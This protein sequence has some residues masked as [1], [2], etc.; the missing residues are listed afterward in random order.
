[1]TRVVIAAER[2][3]VVPGRAISFRSPLRQTY[4][5]RVKALASVTFRR[6][7]EQGPV[8][9]F[10][11]YFHTERRRV[12]MDN[13]SK[14][15]L[16]AMN[17]VAYGDDRQVVNQYSRAYDLTEVFRLP[18]GPVDLIKP[19]A[20]HVEYLFVRVRAVNQSR[21]RRRLPKSHSR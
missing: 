21:P 1:M 12:D 3:F 13:I 8:E 17:G 14:T 4:Q 11:D 18:G 7:P 9:V 5:M 16:D 19:L 15:V 20:Q 2:R 10:L 6:G